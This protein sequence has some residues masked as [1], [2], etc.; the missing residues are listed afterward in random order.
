MSGSSGR[1][2][3]FTTPVEKRRNTRIGDAGG[4][5]GRAAPKNPWKLHEACGP[6]DFG[7]ARVTPAAD[8]ASGPSMAPTGLTPVTAQGAILGTLQYMAPEQL[9]GREADERTDIFAFGCVLYEMLTGMRAF[10]GKTQASV[11]AAILEREPPP[12][13]AMHP[14]MPRALDRLVRKCLAKDPERAH[15]PIGSH[16]SSSR[17]QL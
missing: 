9:E 10:D 7:L 15:L 5:H 12:P 14:A 13:A 2:E 6:L 16:A 3:G 8:A 4:R 1:F 17:V 11:I